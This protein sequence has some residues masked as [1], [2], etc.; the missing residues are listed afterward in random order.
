MRHRRRDS[1]MENPTGRHTGMQRSGFIAYG[2]ALGARRERT[3]PARV[4]KLGNASRVDPSIVRRLG[5]HAGHQP[6]HP[7]SR[8]TNHGRQELVGAAAGA[9]VFTNT[10]TTGAVTR[11]QR[12]RR[13]RRF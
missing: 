12:T 1:A 2:A 4:H 13:T 11:I 7:T 6:G 9:S 3:G 8:D 5:C 10:T